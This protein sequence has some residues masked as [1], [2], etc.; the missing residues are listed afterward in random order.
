MRGTPV[1]STVDVRPSHSW[2]ARTRRHRTARRSPRSRTPF[3]VTGL[4]SN[5]TG[6][7]GVGLFSD[8]TCTTQIGSNVPSSVA[9]NVGGTLSGE[10]TFQVITSGTYYY[11]ISYAGDANNT[12]FSNCGGEQVTVSITSLA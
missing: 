5:A 10:T 8:A 4:T 7:R 1:R 9:A 6:N 12:G 2:S 3:S 11:K